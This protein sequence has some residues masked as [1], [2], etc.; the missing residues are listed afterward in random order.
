MSTQPLASD[1]IIFS[2]GLTSKEDNAR[3]Y[4]IVSN[5]RN[6]LLRQFGKLFEI[7]DEKRRK[8]FVERQEATQISLKRASF[9]HVV[10]ILMF[11]M[12]VEDRVVLFTVLF[13]QNL[14]NAGATF[15]FST[16]N[17]PTEKRE[18]LLF[19]RFLITIVFTVILQCMYS[20]HM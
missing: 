19:G 2:E 14:F 18:V 1:S 13:I 17:Y 10:F 9:I 3:K 6:W 15:F 4:S 11:S 20:C 5:E 8:L 7:E 16:K 12:L